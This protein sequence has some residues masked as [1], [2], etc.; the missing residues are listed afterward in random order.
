MYLT[1]ENVKALLNAVTQHFPRGQIMFDALAP[2]IVKRHGSNV[3]STGATYKWTIGDPLEIKM[4]EPKLDLIREYRT[5]DLVGYSRFP[6]LVRAHYH[7]PR[8]DRMQYILVYRF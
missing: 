3:A 4:L 7:L 2:W 8:M 1:E 5:R 6:L